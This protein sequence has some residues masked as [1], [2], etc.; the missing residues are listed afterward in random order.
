MSKLPVR[1]TVMTPDIYTTLVEL[2][3]QVR[4]GLPWIRNLSMKV[5]QV[6][7]PKDPDLHDMN[8]VVSELSMVVVDH[9]DLEDAL[10]LP[11]LRADPG[12]EP[13][14]GRDLADLAQEHLEIG[15][16]L[17]DL[18][19]SAGQ[20]RIPEWGCLTYRKLMHELRRLETDL[21]RCIHIE[22]HATIH[23]PLG[24]GEIVA[25]SEDRS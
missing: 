2:R 6:H 11:A 9:L 16:L 17:D 23:L 3:N 1:Q 15:Q 18:R 22:N 14:D 24:R 4:G 21:L 25:A 5:A 12:F 10:L 7:G 8:R 19:V 20:F 13:P